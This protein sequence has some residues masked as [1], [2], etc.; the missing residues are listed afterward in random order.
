[1]KTSSLILRLKP[2]LWGILPWEPIKD[3]DLLEAYLR[4]LFRDIPRYMVYKTFEVRQIKQAKIG[5]CFTESISFRSRIV[6]KI[7]SQKLKHFTLY[8]L[9]DIIIG[10]ILEMLDYFSLLSVFF[11]LPYTHREMAKLFRLGPRTTKFPTFT[12]VQHN[13]SKMLY[14]YL[15]ERTRDMR[16]KLISR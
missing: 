16:E 7:K 12:Y 5:M 15:I 9:P 10:R 4:S 8:K 1:M 14:T 2:G 3:R 6:V 11:A 13:L